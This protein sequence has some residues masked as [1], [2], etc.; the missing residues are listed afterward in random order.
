MLK[1][2]VYYAVVYIWKKISILNL[3]SKHM[4]HLLK[5]MF[6]V[7]LLFNNLVRDVHPEIWKL[8]LIGWVGRE[9]QNMSVFAHDLFSNQKW[10]TI[11][12]KVVVAASPRSPIIDVS[13]LLKSPEFVNHCFYQKTF[14]RWIIVFKHT[15]LGWRWRYVFVDEF[16]N[17]LFD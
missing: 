5:K 1:K 6:L 16:L 15:R 7:H 9:I 2:F 13:L 14:E 10:D 4:F 12:V 3:S 8:L 17:H 11:G